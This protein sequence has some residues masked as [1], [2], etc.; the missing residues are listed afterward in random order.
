VSS[1]STTTA[2]T[3]PIITEATATKPSLAP[4]GLRHD[5]NY[6]EERL[7]GNP[8]AIITS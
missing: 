6:W 1:T 3:K 2:S 4:S 8:H 5:S 7:P